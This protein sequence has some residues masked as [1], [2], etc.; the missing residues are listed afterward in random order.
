M[1]DLYRVNM[2]EIKL[3]YIFIIYSSDFFFVHLNY[4]CAT[5]YFQYKIKTNKKKGIHLDNHTLYKKN[6]IKN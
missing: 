3:L 4:V 5:K 6:S 1:S 2:I